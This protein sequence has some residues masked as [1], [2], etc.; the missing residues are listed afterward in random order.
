MQSGFQRHASED[1]LERYSLGVAS[2]AEAEPF[3]EHL[4]VCPECQ[5]RLA[6]MDLFVR[7]TRLAAR[8]L[9]ERPETRWGLLPHLAIPRRVWIAAM[10]GLATVLASAGLWSLLRPG[11]VQPVTVGLAS[12]R[13]HEQPF[14]A[15]AP[16]GRPLRLQLDAAGLP[17]GPHYRLEIVAANGRAVHEAAVQG[18]GGALEATVPSL[19]P[20]RYW[21]RLYSLAP[22]PVLLREFGL[23][24]E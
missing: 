20:G 3:E 12:V 22:Q 1:A 16:A 23:T 5:D 11:S 18:A 6:E 15:R 7:A 21:V 14:G 4:L 19:S 24:A 17:E 9:Q 10:A 2:E 8:N 13:G